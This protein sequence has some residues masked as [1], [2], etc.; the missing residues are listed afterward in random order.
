MAI[1]ELEDAV[2]IEFG[3]VLSLE[4][5]EILLEYV[6]EKL[7]GRVNYTLTVKKDIEPY[8][9]S[10]REITEIALSGTVSEIKTRFATD[11]FVCDAYSQDEKRFE[12]FRFRIVPGYES[13]DQ[14]TQKTK[15]LWAN[16]R[17]I[18]CEYIRNLPEK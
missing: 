8:N 2:T 4:E 12:S 3:R 16:V 9:D 13:L 14:Y 5:T 17:I 6:A 11:E 7:P 15:D 18:I 1:E 10:K